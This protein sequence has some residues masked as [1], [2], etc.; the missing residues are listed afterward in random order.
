MACARVRPLTVMVCCCHVFRSAAQALALVWPSLLELRGQSLR[1]R[2]QALAA[3]LGP[4]PPHQQQQ[5]AAGASA[6]GL[7][8][9][10][11]LD[12]AADVARRYPPALSLAPAAVAARVEALAAAISATAAA[13]ARLQIDL[14]LEPSLDQDQGPDVN[15]NGGTTTTPSP[16]APLGRRRAVDLLVAH[17]GLLGLS[18]N[19]LASRWQ[20]LAAAVLSDAPALGATVERGAAGS[21]AAAVHEQ[22]LMWRQ[23]LFG[24]PAAAVAR[25]LAA[26]ESRLQRLGRVAAHFA[27]V[28]SRASAQEAKPG[29][30]L[31]EREVGKGSAAAS[32]KPKRG[33]GRPW[34]GER[35]GPLS[36]AT[37]IAMS[38]ERFK[39][40][41]TEGAHVGKSATG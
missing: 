41:F 39:Q 2:L 37:V 5:P 30:E 10:V 9:D 23:Q 7:A 36:L 38:E 34:A 33:R 25:C 40:R 17:P 19:A 28:A 29:L 14:T 1:G 11:D 16:Y 35:L 26:S 3:E 6:P 24:C 8:S 4:S 15:N 22:R 21:A 32:L 27:A 18:P 20:E 13:V 12:V 31:D